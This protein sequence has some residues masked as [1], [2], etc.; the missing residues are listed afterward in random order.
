MELFKDC[1]KKFENYKLAINPI[2]L[3]FIE[4]LLLSG[5]QNQELRYSL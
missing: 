4:T 3:L 5:K 1:N 2:Y